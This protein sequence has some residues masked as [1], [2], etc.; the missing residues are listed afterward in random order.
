MTVLARGWKYSGVTGI[1]YR[2]HDKGLSSE[3][4]LTHLAWQ[5]D[6]LTGNRKMIAETF[7]PE[8]VYKALMMRI[9]KTIGFRGFQFVQ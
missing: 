5:L 3:D 6:V 7:G 4:A 2:V 8:E 1:G 9:V